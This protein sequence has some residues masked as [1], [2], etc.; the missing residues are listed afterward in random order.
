MNLLAWHNFLIAN[1]FKNWKGFPHI[2]QVFAIETW[3]IEMYLVHLWIFLKAWFNF[4]PVFQR[5]SGERK[6]MSSFIQRT[7]AHFFHIM[8]LVLFTSMEKELMLWVELL[9]RVY[10][11]LKLNLWMWPVENGAFDLTSESWMVS[12]DVE[13][14]TQYEYECLYKKI[15]THSITGGEGLS[16]TEETMNVRKEAETGM[17]QPYKP[18]SPR[19]TAT[20][21]H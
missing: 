2:R 3:F 6:E 13:P 1:A 14:M 19:V 9:P 15:W 10:E 21:D 4:A 8:T 16:D 20:T 11:V 12:L 7:V 18:G 17:L 5:H